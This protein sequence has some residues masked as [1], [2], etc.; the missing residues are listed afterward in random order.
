M[1][2]PS[3]N[4]NLET[5]DAIQS[6]RV[7]HIREC[8]NLYR[9]RFCLGRSFLSSQA[10]LSRVAGVQNEPTDS[11]VCRHRGLDDLHTVLDAVELDVVPE[12]TNEG[13]IGLDGNH[14][15]RV[16]HQG[17]DPKRVRADV[18]PYVHKSEAG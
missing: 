15:A 7:D 16:A 14:T 11:T 18:G 17:Q 10:I 13:W 9:N 4:V 6:S 12:L 1:R 3:L 2:L 5:V 8:N